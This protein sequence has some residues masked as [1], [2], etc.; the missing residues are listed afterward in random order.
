MGLL[1]SE[2]HANASRYPLG[3]LWNEVL[4]TRGRVNARIA[5]EAAVMHVVIVQSLAG[6][7]HLKEVLEQLTDGA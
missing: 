2:G 7:D 3:Y 6:G 4:F 5:S 1:L